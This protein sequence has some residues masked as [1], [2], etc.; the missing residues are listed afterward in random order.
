MCMMVQFLKCEMACSIIQRILFT[1]ALH[2]F[3][4]SSSSPPAGF[5]YGVIMLSRLAFVA[6]PVLRVRSGTCAPRGPP[7]PMGSPAARSASWSARRWLRV[8]RRAR[9]L[10]RQ[11]RPSRPPRPSGPEETAGPR[12]RNRTR[13]SP[14]RTPRSTGPSALRHGTACIPSSTAT[15]AGSPEGKTCRSCAAPSST[16]PSSVSRTDV[17]CTALCGYGTSAPGRCPA[18]KRTEAASNRVRGHGPCPRAWR[19]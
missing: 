16:S 11:V 1:P 2:S 14:C 7:S 18:L 17:T 4:Q 6:D 8:L 9:Y 5:L 3:C 19:R 12:T 13:N 10:G 15:A